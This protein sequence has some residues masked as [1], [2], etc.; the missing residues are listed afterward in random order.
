MKRRIV[1][2]VVGCLSFILSL[3]AQIASSGSSSAQVPPLIQFS[4]V[5]ADEGGNTL[6]GVVN[7]NFSLYAAQRGGEPLWTETQNVQLDSSGHY[8]VQL[9][10]TKPNGVPTTL[11]TTG[12]A[13]W[14]GI[15]IA[16][17]PEQPRVLLL[18]VPYALKAGDAATLGGL[19]ASAFVLAAPPNGV[20]PAYTAEAATGQSVSPGTATDVTTSGGTVN[21]LP[22]WDTTSDI[23]SS[24]LFQSGTGATARI[25]INTATP[26]STL[27]IK[28]GST[29]RGILSLPVTGNATAAAGKNS[30]PLSLAASAFNSGSSAATSQTF[31]LQAEPANNDSSSPSGTLNLLFGEGTATPTETGLH[32]ASNGQITFAS[33]QTFPGAGTGDGTVTSVASGAGLSGGPITS[34]GTL[35]IANGGVTNAMLA[36]PSLTVAVG[37]GLTGGGSVALGGSTTAL[38]IAPNACTSGSALSALPFTCSPFAQLGANTFTGIQTITGNLALPNTNSGGT[39]GVILFGGLPFIHDYGPAAS[40]NSFFGYRAGNLTTTGSF[41]AA[42]GDYALANNTSGFDN[43]A[44]GYGA[45]DS[46]TTGPYNTASGFEAL[47]LNTVGGYNAAIGYEALHA[48]VTASGNVAVGFAAAQNN[49][50]NFNTAV[51]DSA[52]INN[53]TGTNNTALGIS[54]GPSAGGL[55]N[56]TAIGSNATVSESNALVLGGTGANAVSVGIGTATPGATLDVRGTGNFTGLVT[57]AAG[58]T[59]PGAPGL[60][61]ANTFTAAQTINAGAA[62]DG[63]EVIGSGGASIYALNDSTSGVSNG[64]NAW[65]DSTVGTG[66]SGVAYGQSNTASNYIAGGGYGVWGDSSLSNTVGT[67]GVGVLGTADDSFASVMVNDSSTWATL[68]MLNLYDSDATTRSAP[69]LSA[70]GANTGKGCTMDVSGTLNCEG[71]VTAVVPTNTG[72]RKVSLYAVQS[73]E[74]WFEDFGSGA[75]IDGATMIT[76]DPTFTQTVNTATEYHVFLT[77]NGDSKGLYVSRK[78]ATS[79]EVREQGGGHSSIAFDYRIVA[80]RSGYEKVRLADVTEQYRKMAEQREL[81]RGRA[82]ARPVRPSVVPQTIPTPPIPALRAEAGPAT[83]QSK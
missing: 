79:F 12:E 78:T 36:N 48:N 35:S 23:V 57:F 14:L 56:T 8:S 75:L 10:I 43:T 58:Q 9:G 13:R 41:L 32:I 63:L 21:Y 54:A 5:A 76:L 72:G 26:V 69:L 82:G 65:A 80:K 50:A 25:G 68:Y 52:L 29:V 73:P 42:V 81:R 24:V 33:G 31:R 1:C 38:A 83:A 34:S 60:G 11:F 55:S 46:N 44:S 77:P 6:S 39:Q 28:G 19:P 3:S 71:T 61:T 70:Y 16:Q 17:Q 62:G 51:G 15:E 30:Q 53:I 64:I 22:L 47:Y 18:S 45:L 67:L 49:T 59:V 66:L 27:D 4:N 74:N 37:T 20:T 40:Y 7:I 2:V